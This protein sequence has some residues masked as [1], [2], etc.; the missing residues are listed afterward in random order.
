MN[1]G[2]NMASRIIDRRARCSQG[3]SLG[4]AE[5]MLRSQQATGPVDERLAK[6]AGPTA[7]CAIA[8]SGRPEQQKSIDGRRGRVAVESPDRKEKH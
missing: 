1:I 2:L 4:A 8:V 3:L 5:L 7:E 6:N